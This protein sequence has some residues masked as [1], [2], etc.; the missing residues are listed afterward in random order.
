[1]SIKIINNHVLRY[2]PYVSEQQYASKIKKPGT[3]PGFLITY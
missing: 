1:M 2:V 3:R